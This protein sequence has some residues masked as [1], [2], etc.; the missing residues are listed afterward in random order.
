MEVKG[1]QVELIDGDAA[2]IDDLTEVP[3][4]GFVCL[5]DLFELLDYLEV[6]STIGA[7]LDLSVDVVRNGKR[8]YCPSEDVKSGRHASPFLFDYEAIN[9]ITAIA[10]MWNT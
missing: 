2:V 8:E 7:R 1:N 3:D 6:E 5:L 10:R 9:A 4:L